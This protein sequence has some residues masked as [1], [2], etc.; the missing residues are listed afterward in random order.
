MLNEGT[1]ESELL[2]GRKDKGVGT[3]QPLGDSLD[4]PKGSELRG[5][6]DRAAQ[7]LPFLQ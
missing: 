6:Q 3:E 4:D 7:Y 1:F 5:F 2:K